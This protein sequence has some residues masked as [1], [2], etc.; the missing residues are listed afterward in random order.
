MKSPIIAGGIDDNYVYPYLISIISAQKRCETRINFLLAYDASHLSTDSRSLI[1][2]VTE[3]FGISLDFIEIELPKSLPSQGH[4]SAMAFAPLILADRLTDE[5]IWLDA[6]TVCIGELDLVFD[7]SFMRHDVAIVARTD[8]SS[9]RLPSKNKA[10]KVAGRRYLNSGVMKINPL[11]WQELNFPYLWKQ[12][13]ENYEKFNFRLADQCVINYLIRGGYQDLPSKYNVLVFGEDVNEGDSI[14]HFAGTLKPWNSSLLPLVVSRAVLSP[15]RLA[16]LTAETEII[17]S[18][19]QAPI[20][21]HK[22]MGTRAGKGTNVRSNTHKSPTRQKIIRE[23]LKKCYVDT[24]RSQQGILQR[25]S[26]INIGSSAGIVEKHRKML[27]FE[28]ARKLDFKVRYGPFKGMQM[29]PNLTWGMSDIAPMLLGTYEKPVVEYISSN[30]GKFNSF[31]NLG[32][33]DGFYVI[34]MTNSNLA[35]VSYAYEVSNESQL[36]IKRNAVL[37]NVADRV[38]IRGVATKDFIGDFT[39]EELANSLILID[40]EGGEF[41]MFREIDLTSLEQTRIV[42]ELHDFVEGSEAKVPEFIS[43]LLSTHDVSVFK[44]SN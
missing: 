41:D 35:K 14:L 2:D 17:D 39:Q 26:R 15:A 31:I 33:G 42:I 21:L 8:F 23:F 13:V 10:R 22:F 3:L 16:Y 40:I 18:L 37:N 4:I 24:I 12:A 6:D 30:R 36:N 19:R 44:I 9:I 1:S 43:K 29:N 20:L 28:L 38:I 5:F 32:A 27:S 7:D 34:G 25:A 11:K